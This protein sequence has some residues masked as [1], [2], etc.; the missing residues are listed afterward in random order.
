MD[1]VG[2]ETGQSQSCQ[3]GVQS[4]ADPITIGRNVPCSTTSSSNVGGVHLDD[5]Y[6]S[7]T[8][9]GQIVH[10]KRAV[11][12]VVILMLELENSTS[13]ISMESHPAHPLPSSIRNLKQTDLGASSFGAATCMIADRPHISQ[14]SR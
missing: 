8:Q 13:T 7:M 9:T 4:A 11:G 1:R 2:S 12:C 10:E 3:E 5:V 6:I 14:A